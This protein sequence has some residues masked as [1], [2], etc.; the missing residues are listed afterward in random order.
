[1]FN[2]ATDLL[3]RNR[4]QEAADILGR[5]IAQAKSSLAEQGWSPQDIQ[6]EVAAI[7]AQRAV[8]LQQLGKTDEA[9]SI[10][11]QLLS[12]TALDSAAR[13]VVS[14]N[15]AATCVPECSRR[16]IGLTS[17]KR[18]LQI[19]S[20]AS[21]SLSRSQ[22]ALM[23]YNMAAIQLSQGQYVA[24]RRS[25]ARLGKLFS[26]V[27]VPNAG[28][29]SACISLHTGN[30][31]GAL[32]EL[33]ALSRALAPEEGVHTTLAAAQVAIG[34]GDNRRAADILETWSDRAKNVPLQ[35]VLEPAKFIY[36]LFGVGVL[37]DWLASGGNGAPSVPAD[38][39]KRLKSE[40]DKVQSPSASLLI[41]V[42]D[43]FAF[44]GDLEQAKAYFSQASKAA[45]DS[46][47]AVDKLASAHMRAILASDGSKQSVAQLLKGYTKRG[48]V[49][50]AVPGVSARFTR[51]FLPRSNAAGRSAAPRRSD[52]P[53]APVSGRSKN[54]SE[55]YRARRQRRLLKRPPKGY[56]SEHKP[57]SERWLPLRQRSYY[58][59]RGRNRRQQ[60]LRGGAQGGATE[61][62]AGLGG[63]G[64]SRIA[65]YV[66]DAAG[67]QADAAGAQADAESS[68]AQ[69]QP[70]SNPSKSKTKAGKGK[71]K[72][73]K[74]KKGW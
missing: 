49:L 45:L 58:R 36:Y 18:A 30:A 1:M 26:N 53:T 72:K 31:Q 68:S 51:Q 66:A 22:R 6:A 42:G 15:A 57:D 44:A 25:L 7:E 37:V 32:D 16:G 40:L 65:G 69:Q 24:A 71:A 33:A 64:S 60:K 55:K 27:I 46:G 52:I 43:C 17:I 8:A 13:E 2:S 20:S 48:R 21:H 63:T 41:A 59:P 12:G 74:G 54:K 29:V 73:G 62:G 39:A 67:A 70:S 14:H 11:S 34:L 4:A 50:R 5:A 35:S 3:A 38:A 56:D 28:I 9:R 10:Y 61:A 47:L 23:T 19:R